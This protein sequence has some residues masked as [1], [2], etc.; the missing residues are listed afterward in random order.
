MSKPAITK[1]R[2]F[3]QSKPPKAKEGELL[4]GLAHDVKINSEALEQFCFRQ[5]TEEEEELVLLTGLVAFTDRSVRRLVANGW[6]RSLQITMPVKDPEF[7]NRHAVTSTLVDALRF[8]SGDDWTFEFAKRTG[9]IPKPKQ[10]ELALGDGKFVVMPFS[11][12]LD[13]FS[14][15][16]LFSVQ[17]PGSS[18]IHLTA[19]NRSLS[20]GRDWVTESGGNRYRR[21]SLPVRLATDAHPDQ[22]FRTR[23][24][25]FSTLAGLASAMSNAKVILIPEAGQGALGPS[26]ITVGHESPHR[27]SH[28]KFS[29]LMSAFFQAFWGKPIRIE[30]PHVWKTKGEVLQ[31]LK[32]R[33]LEAGY[34]D[35]TS[36]ARDQRVTSTERRKKIQCGICSGCLLRRMSLFSANLEDS[37]SNYFWDD[38]TAP[39]LE[40]ALCADA[41]RKVSPNDRD[42]AVHSILAMEELARQADVASDH[43]RLQHALVDAGGILPTQSGTSHE[44]QNLLVNHKREW[45]LFTDTLGSASWISQQIRQM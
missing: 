18:A 20:G 4:C 40:K 21:V 17:V 41:R 26:L 31:E 33:G 34:K 39:S 9:R 10:A 19:W 38:L 45:R 37:P 12:G 25:M 16:R 24:F 29:R 35:T 14:Q 5:L 6:T 28:P 27:G 36:C 11:N 43:P 42:I 30:H 32:S 44:L 1:V 3:W 15:S 23:S 8:L 2:A 7:W 22:T 13:S